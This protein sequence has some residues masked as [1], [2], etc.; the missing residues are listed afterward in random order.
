VR[1]RLSQ[2]LLDNLATAWSRLDDAR[3]LDPADVPTLLFALDEWV[4]WA[5]RIDLEL[6]AALG[7][8][9][10]TSRVTRPGG[11][12]LPALHLAADLTERTG[13]PIGA[14]VTVSAGSPAVF[15]DAVWRRYEELPA[16]ELETERA[17]AYR[18]HLAG[19]AARRPASE[20]TTFLLGAAVA[21]AAER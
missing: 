7:D 6:L 10:A 2:A 17:D 12:P 21:G 15:Y 4:R 1:S 20:V 16:S 13:H 3:P 11:L 9:Y 18:L 5:V 19:Q 14:L 8:E